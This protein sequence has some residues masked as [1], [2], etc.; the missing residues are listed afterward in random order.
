MGNIILPQV[1][2]VSSINTGIANLLIEQNGEIQRVNVNKF[3]NDKLNSIEEN[4]NYFQL[5]DA[6]I[7]SNHLQNNIIDTDHIQ[8]NS[9]TADKIMDGVITLNKLNNDIKQAFSSSIQYYKGTLYAD[10]WV[11]ETGTT[12]DVVKNMENKWKWE[13]FASTTMA[14][15][16]KTTLATVKPTEIRYIH[17]V[18]TSISMDIADSYTARC[19]TYVYAMYDM[20]FPC[21][22][23]TDDEGRVFCNGT[24]VSAIKSCAV[25]NIT[26]PLK[27]GPNYIEVYYTES[28]GGDGWYFGPKLY[29]RVGYEF[30][31]MSA[32]PSVTWQQVITPEC[33][34][35][36]ESNLTANT[37]LSPAIMKT[38][39]YQD[40]EYKNRINSGYIAP[41]DA[42]TITVHYLNT[43]PIDRDLTVYWFGI[44]P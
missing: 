32:T 31:A 26:L 18:D 28:S 1:N 29:E 2:K 35:G 10:R 9:I 16:I 15:T 7:N 25:T 44:N 11:S 21:T 39:D 43:T 8:N 24:L 14:D 30:Y 17:D 3:T 6:S 40:A 41:D 34:F 23:C 42:G 5:S 38:E 19:T 4:A 37:I 22:C 20:N 27:K 12:P 13:K 33:I 36:G